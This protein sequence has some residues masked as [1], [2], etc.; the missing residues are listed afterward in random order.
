MDD[1]CRKSG[2]KVNL[3]KS[4]VFFS[5]NI[6]EN[7]ADFLS[8]ELGIKQTN[9]LGIYLGAPMLHKRLSKNNISFILGKMRKSYFSPILSL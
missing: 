7:E 4:E 1:F 6:V 5:N 8:H 3:L 9:D 2:Q